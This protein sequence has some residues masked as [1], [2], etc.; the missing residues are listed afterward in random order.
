V[1]LPDY[2]M[3]FRKSGRGTG[4]IKRATSRDCLNLEQTRRE[5]VRQAFQTLGLDNLTMAHEMADAYSIERE[6]LIYLFP[7]AEETLQYLRDHQVAL[8]LITNGEAQKQR[9]KVQRFGLERFFMTIPIEGEVG[10]GKPEEAIYVQALADLGLA[11]EAM[12]P[13]G[14]NLEWD[15][16][17]PQKLGMLGIWHD[18]RGQ[19]LSP[20]SPI[21]PDRT[22]TSI[23]EL[24]G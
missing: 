19:G 10:F 18:F 23:S 8:A 2:I 5:I 4:P 16:W 24:M 21:I 11:P 14:D 9:Q 7:R 3:P 20:G 13:V 12:W 1:T 15:V 6:A 17:V 22:I